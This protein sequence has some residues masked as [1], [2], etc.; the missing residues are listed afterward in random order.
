MT[1]R[2]DGGLNAAVGPGRVDRRGRRRQPEHHAGARDRSI[3]EILAGEVNPWGGCRSPSPWIWVRRR[4]PSSPDSA[5]R[6]PATISYRPP[7]IGHGCSGSSGSS[8]RRDRSCRATIEA[9]PRLLVRCDGCAGSWRIDQGVYTA[10]LGSS[11]VALELTPRSSW[12]AT[13]SEGNRV[14]AMN[15]G[16]R[17]SLTDGDHFIAACAPIR[18]AGFRTV[19][20][21]LDANPAPTVRVGTGQ[22]GARVVTSHFASSLSV[23]R[24]SVTGGI[25]WMVPIRLFRK[26]RGY[27]IP[28]T[29]TP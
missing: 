25:R 24:I 23:S 1:G 14:T 15:P 28:P 5:P 4:G 27:H 3:T 16:G 19:A 13:S 22:Q 7:S 8:S 11:A 29:P 2:D 20:F 6:G 10:A 21:D 26:G 9:D 12:S 17:G 18:G